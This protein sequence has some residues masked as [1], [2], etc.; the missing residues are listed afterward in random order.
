MNL[1]L[2]H[3]QVHGSNLSLIA[4]RSGVVISQHKPAVAGAALHKLSD[5]PGERRNTARPSH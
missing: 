4:D 1:G 2:E 5:E 3:V